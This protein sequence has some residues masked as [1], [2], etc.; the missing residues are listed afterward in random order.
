MPVEFRRGDI[1]VVASHN[2]HKLEEFADLLR[3]FGLAVISAGTLGIAEPE[4]TGTTFEANAELK[5]RAVA[6]ASGLPSLADDSGLVVDAL[7]GEPGIYSARWAGPTRDFRKAMQAVEDKLQALGAGMAERRRAR[8]VAAL[9]LALPDGTTEMFRGEVE[10]TLTWPSRGK[11]GFGYD[12]MFVPDGFMRT[13]G[14]M[15]AS[16]KQGLSHRARAFAAF[17]RA[18]LAP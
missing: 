14:E 7:G 5:A 12:P 1:M 11:N 18:R 2:Q 16:E 3:P 17:A 10:G 4:E 15:S 8:F 13:F 6:M 9:S